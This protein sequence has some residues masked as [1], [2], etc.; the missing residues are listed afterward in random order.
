[1]GLKLTP[2]RFLSVICSNENLGR[3]QSVQSLIAKLVQHV[4]FGAPL[5]RT[6]ANLIYSCRLTEWT[7]MPKLCNVKHF[8]EEIGISMQKLKLAVFI[9]H[10][11][12]LS[13]NLFQNSNLMTYWKNEKYWQIYQNS[14]PNA[15]P[16]C[17]SIYL[18][19]KSIKA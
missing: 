17:F 1:M 13:K 11:S 10:F 8:M 14:Y 19:P 15:S 16:L 4:H 2:R 6:V 3:T 9:K 12:V 5:R 18:D 7:V